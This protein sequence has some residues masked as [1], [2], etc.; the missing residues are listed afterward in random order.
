M[1]Q[2]VV[3]LCVCSLGWTSSVAWADPVGAIG[4]AD[5]GA[6]LAGAMYGSDD[7]LSAAAYNPAS[8]A[9]AKRA[10]LG[11]GVSMAAPELTLNNLDAGLAST[12]ALTAALNIPIELGKQWRIALNG[13]MYLPTAGIAQIELTAPTELQVV[14]WDNRLRRVASEFCAAVAYKDKLSLGLGVSVFGGVAGD[15]LDLNVSTLPGRTEATTHLQVDVPWRFSPYMGLLWKAKSYLSL[16]V[17]YR[18]PQKLDAQIYAQSFVSVPGTDIEGDTI[19]RANGIDFYSPRS[20]HLAASLELDTWRL[21]AQL[22]WQQ[23]SQIKQV[24]SNV[25]LLVQLGIDIDAISLDLPAPHWN[26]VVIP[27]LA[28]EHRI[29]LAPTELVYLRLGYAYIHSPVPDQSGL[30]SF[31]DASRHVFAGGAAYEFEAWQRRFSFGLALQA[32]PLV[33]RTTIKDPRYAFASDYR[34]SGTVFSGSLFMRVELTK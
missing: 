19:I 24:A 12:T 27:R 15:G 13:V 6:A 29:N 18:E 14:L 30:S 21:Y 3:R 23:W 16:G 11:L 17:A 34:L 26:D 32:Q 28:L 2:F 8:A 10:S 22:D 25:D 33:P 4:F 5:R 31:A 7:A 20:L 1:K 9:F